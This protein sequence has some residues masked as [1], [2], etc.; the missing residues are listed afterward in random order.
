MPAPII[1]ASERR[2]AMACPQRWWWSYRE[3]LK[4]KSEALGP[5]WFGTGVHIALAKWYI[6][7]GLKRG[8]EPAETWA[9]FAGEAVAYVKT[10]D[11]TDEQ[12][13]KYEDAVTLGDA[14]LEGY[15]AQYGRDEH[16]H[17]ISPEQTFSLELPWPL[18]QEVYHVQKG[19]VMAVHAGTFDLVYRDLRHDWLM[20]EEHKTAKAI[21]TKHLELDDQGGTYWAVATRTLRARKLIGPNEV[22][23]GIEYN[24]L[25]KGLPDDRPRDAQGYACNKPIKADYINALTADGIIALQGKGLDKQ[26]LPTLVAEAEKAGLT[27]LGERSKVQPPPLFVR[28]MVHR[29]KTE[30]ATQ[31]RRLQDQALYLQ[32]LRDGTLPLTKNP[33]RECTFCDFYNMCELQERGGDWETFRDM[34]YRVEDPYADHRKSTEE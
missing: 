27:V 25:R 29:T 22:L 14:M 9:Q 18:G 23:R 24:F 10:A 30:Q 12:V 21:M 7:P 6:G 31:L 2:T 11:A 19:S 34:T 1:R 28:H 33:T 4:P 32:V 15:R 13:A 16:M 26:T 5:L 20:L 3:G 8:P 17:I